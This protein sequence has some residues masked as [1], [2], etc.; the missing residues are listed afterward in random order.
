MLVTSARGPQQCFWRQPYNRKMTSTP[1]SPETRTILL[2]DDGDDCRITTKWFLSNFG[3]AVDAV[4][5][6]EDALSLFD[7]KIHDLVVTDNAMP[8]MT[9]AEMAHV[10]KLRSPSTPVLMYSGNAPDDRSCLDGVV[11]RPAHLLALKDAIE[12]LLARNGD[13]AQ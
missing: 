3:Y 11:Q 2:V 6:A 1:A 13:S 9:G 8:G 7:P 5:T 4:R 12:R 10:I